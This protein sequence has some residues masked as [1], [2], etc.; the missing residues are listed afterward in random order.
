MV[1]AEK[2]DNGRPISKLMKPISYFETY[3]DAYG[4][5]L[6]YNRNP[7]A[8]NAS[9]TVK[10]LHDRWALVYVKRVTA[11]T[12]ERSCHT[13]NLC[14]PM[15]DYQVSELRAHVIREFL[16]TKKSPNTRV[17]IRD[18][19]AMMLDYAVENDIAEKNVARDIDMQNEH[20]EREAMRESHISFTDE[21]MELLWGNAGDPIVGMMLIQCYCG[22]RPME[23]CE[24]TLEN[25]NLENWSIV[26]GSKTEAGRDRTVPIHE[27]K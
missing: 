18:L 6:E 4:A 11:A 3:K 15:Y 17:S 5:S 25:I 19:F 27:K 14:Q 9:M 16:N 2:T 13:W 23:L 24:I 20:R 7:Y 1:P 26:G 10:E 8:A 22:W 12:Y 21:E